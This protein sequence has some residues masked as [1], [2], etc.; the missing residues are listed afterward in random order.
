MS[1]T[2]H[3]NCEKD[4]T[5]TTRPV[6]RNMMVKME[7]GLKEAALMKVIMWDAHCRQ[8]Y[9]ENQGAVNEEQ[10]AHL[11]LEKASMKYQEFCKGLENDW[12]K[13][14]CNYPKT[15]NVAY[16]LLE[17][18]KGSK[19]IILHIVQKGKQNDRS[20]TNSSSKTNLGFSFN[21]NGKSGQ[22]HVQGN[23]NDSWSCFKCEKPGHI[24]PNCT[25]TT[26]E[27]GS[28]LNNKEQANILQNKTFA[29]G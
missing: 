15:V 23:K 28:P 5:L 13:K 11:F 9:L 21:Q 29:L 1:L 7:P 24:S 19:T 27:D 14:N 8:W 25:E 2:H 3:E 10:L 12:N 16:T 18:Y 4:A 20:G 22:Q 6:W 26:K 17:T